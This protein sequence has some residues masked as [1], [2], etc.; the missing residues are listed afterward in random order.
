VKTQ[1]ITPDQ[2]AER[3]C[4]RLNLSPRDNA[5]AISLTLRDALVGRFETAVATT[6]A[7][8]LTIAEEEAE[9]C[10][11]VGASTA[12]VVALNI[13]SRIRNRHTSSHDAEHRLKLSVQLGPCWR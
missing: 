1:S 13:A 5:E 4:R 11:R 10:R 2:L 9:R 6:K 12:E 3:I 7:A 8:C